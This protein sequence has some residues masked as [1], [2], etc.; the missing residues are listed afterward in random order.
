MAKALLRFR[1]PSRLVWAGLVALVLLLRTLYPPRDLDAL[2]PVA[3]RDG[4][5][6]IVHWLAFLLVAASAGFWLLRKLAPPDLSELEIMVFAS[7]LGLGQMAYLALGLGLSGLLYPAVLDALTVA[8]AFLTESDLRRLAGLLTSL[9]RG[10]RGWLKSGSPL[11]P[12]SAALMSLIALFALIH[13]LGPAWDYDGLMYH[14]PGPTGFLANH[15]IL[16]NLDNWYV[17]GPFTVEMLFTY[18]LAHGD[19][20]FA[21]LIHYALGWLYVMSAVAVARRWLGAREAWL[22]AVILMGIPTLPIW[23]AFAYVDLGWA[24][25]E[26]LAAGAALVFWQTGSRRWLL[27]AGLLAGLAMGSKY[28]GLAGFAA[29]LGLVAW[30]GWRAGLRRLLGDVSFFATAAVVVALPWYLKNW[31]WFGNPVYPLYLGGP[32]WEAERLRVYMAYLGSFGAGRTFVDWILLPLNIYARNA[33]FGAVMNQ[34]DVPSLLFPLLILYPLRRGPRALGPLLAFA[35]GRSLLWALSSQQTR[36]LLP[37]FPAL[38]VATAHLVSS[39]VPRRPGRM[40][41]HIFLPTLAVALS[42]LTLFYQVVVLVKYAPHLPAGGWE[43]SRQF[44]RRIVRDYPA[45]D[46]LNRSLPP[47]ARAL[48][49]GDGRAFYCPEKCVP[50]PDHFRWAAEINRFSSVTEFAGWMKAEGF[51]H[52]LLSWEDVDFLLQHDPTST[53]LDAVRRLREWMPTECFRAVFS[54][55]WSTLAEVICE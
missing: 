13:T 42:G 1:L 35:A 7:A 6:S 29:L 8:I 54:D 26:F 31:L 11:R 50:D 55:E 51:S 52:L 30:M 25:F 44:L 45:V 23:A 3:L 34:I 39:L 22:S 24:S 33:R 2:G 18:G 40:P 49:L 53:M 43:S 10:L 21:K 38:A 32:G 16:P 14:L 41:W 15:R 46:F 48:Q 47:S 17:N 28:T 37:V 9:A 36:F 5:L 20:A 4:A 12:A 27:L 19:V